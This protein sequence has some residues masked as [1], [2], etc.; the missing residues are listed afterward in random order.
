VKDD[1]TEEKK[2]RRGRKRIWYKMEA[3]RPSR[4]SLF[5]GVIILGGIAVHDN[6]YFLWEYDSE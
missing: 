2:S 6:E 5:V 4:Y 1:V 3:G